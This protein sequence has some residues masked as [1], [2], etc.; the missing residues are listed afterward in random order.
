M[1]RVLGRSQFP[2]ILTLDVEVEQAFV[3]EARI[4]LG[5]GDRD[6]LAVAEQLGASLGAD[7]GRQ[8]QLAADDGRVAGP[9]AAI[10]D[11]GRRLL[12]DRF[13][14]G[15]GLV[16]D[17][18]LAVAELMQ[19]LHLLDHAHRPPADLLADAP[20]ADQHPALGPQLVDLDRV[21]LLLRLDGLGTCLDD[22][23]LACPPV[24][25]PFHVHRR[26]PAALGAVVVLDQAGPAR[27]VSGSRRR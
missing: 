22:E 14:V 16:G 8:A 7:D 10:G 25:G 27:P 20:A 12:H 26:G 2:K 18:H 21:R 15:I 4:A 19:V 24:L 3:D 6:L 9:A 1:I 17:E 23:Q 13:P 11:D 5:A